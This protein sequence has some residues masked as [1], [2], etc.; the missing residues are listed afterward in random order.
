VRAANVRLDG[1]PANAT[2]RGAIDL[3]RWALDGELTLEAD[4]ARAGQR[5]P[6]ITLAYAGPLDEPERRIDVRAFVDFLNL[7]R[8]EREVER[9]ERLQREAE[10]RERLMRQLEEQERARRA[11]LTPPPADAP[12]VATPPAEPPRAEPRPAAPIEE[13]GADR[14]RFDRFIREALREPAEPPRP[15]LAPLPPPVVVAPAPPVR[16]APRGPLPL[17]PR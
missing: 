7:R 15:A 17:I 10:E 12:T 9:L 1:R 2:V 11:R 3:G 14:E 13:R 4:G 6:R 8:F 16:A 5:G